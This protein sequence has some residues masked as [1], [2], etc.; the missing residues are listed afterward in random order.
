[1]FRRQT[2]HAPIEEIIV[3]LFAQ[4][5]TLTLYLLYLVLRQVENMLIFLFAQLILSYITYF[6]YL[7][8]RQVENKLIC[9]DLHNIILLHFTYFIQFSGK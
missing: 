8:L 2:F 4:H 3:F 6:K 9:F 1:M 5:N 7:I